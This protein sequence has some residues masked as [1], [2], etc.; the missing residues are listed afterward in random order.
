MN[1]NLPIIKTQLHFNVWV[2]APCVY[3]APGAIFANYLVSLVSAAALPALHALSCSALGCAVGGLASMIFFLNTSTNELCQSPNELIA[4][5]ALH[6]VL[7][8]VTSVAL[9]VLQG[10][11]GFSL[12]TAALLPSI[13]F[14]SGLGLFALKLAVN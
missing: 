12:V 14:F 7:S 1:S 8:S 11:S 9:A 10:F 13:G 5:G 4:G 3:G 6:L 2:G